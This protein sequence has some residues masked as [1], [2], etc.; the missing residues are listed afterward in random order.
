MERTKRKCT[1]H[2][3]NWKETMRAHKKQCNLARRRTE[4]WH[5]QA[6]I[7]KPSKMAGKIVVVRSDS[8]VHHAPEN[9]M[10]VR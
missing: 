9:R 2:A 4:T 3:A 8:Q 7:N 5:N 10:D 6:A 1:E